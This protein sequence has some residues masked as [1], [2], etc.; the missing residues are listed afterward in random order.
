[1]LFNSWVFAF[2]LPLVLAVYYLLP[3]RG[4]NAFLLAASYVFY[5]Y[6]DWRFLSLL[7]VSTVVDYTVGLLLA[8]TEAEPR[9]RFLIAASCVVNLTLLGFFKYFNFFLE[10]AADIARLLHLPLDTPT[11]N[12]VLPMGISF[13][14]F[15]TMSYTID[16]F[17]RE[18]PAERS[19]LDFALYITYFPQLVAGPI[20]RAR[21]LLPQF[22]EQRRI[23]LEDLRIG[24]WLLLKG[25]FMKLVVADNLG[26]VVDDVFSGY[27]KVSGGTALA[28]T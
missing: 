14:T 18:V 25:F 7:L 13:Y 12:I 10:G 19:L 27:G 17:R 6:W 20:E 4:Q 8:R 5:G 1:M 23:T 3:R 24:L 28:A 26:V 11:L 16:V 15:Q 9:R 22:K 2:Y 21:S